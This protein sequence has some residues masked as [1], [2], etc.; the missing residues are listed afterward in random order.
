MT[1]PLTLATVSVADA[2]AGSLRDRVLDGELAPRTPVAETEVA[3]EYRVSRPTAKSAI[4]TLVLEGLLR[5]EANK[6]A[7]VPHLSRADV[8]D[9]FLV[10]TPL[11]TEAVRLLVTRGTAPIDEVAS[12]VDDLLKLPPEAPHSRFAAADLRF[13]RIL[14][15]AVRSPRLTRVYQSIQGEIHLCMV[16]TRHELG[17]DRIAAEHRA[18]LEAL[19]ANDPQAAA[20]TIR[21]HLE[22]AR[23]SLQAVFEQPL[24]DN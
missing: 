16:Q 19:R 13:H 24:L 3:S 11:E 14:V 8:E 4:T 12:A 20:A 9:L 17:R 22:G 5:R 23:A 18:V 2:L 6:R 21:T 15:D 10:R 1:N 7:Y